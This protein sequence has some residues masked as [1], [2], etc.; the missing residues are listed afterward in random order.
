MSVN[1]FLFILHLRFKNY[2]IILYFYSFSIYFKL[3]YCN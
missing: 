1:L 3:D 2:A